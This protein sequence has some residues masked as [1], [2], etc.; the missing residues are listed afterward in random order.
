MHCIWTTQGEVVCSKEH[1]TQ[2]DKKE[3]TVVSV[4]LENTTNFISDPREFRNVIA[5]RIS[6]GD[7][8][9]IKGHAQPNAQFALSKGSFVVSSV[10]VP[11]NPS[12]PVEISLASSVTMRPGKVTLIPMSSTVNNRS[13][14]PPAGNNRSP[15]TPPVATTTVTTA[16]VM[17]RD[18]T[19]NV[20]TDTM[21]SLLFVSSSDA[22]RFTQG[23]DIKITSPNA[24]N[25]NARIVRKNAFTTDANIHQIV[26]DKCVNIRL[27]ATNTIQFL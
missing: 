26:L 8:D 5:F 2:I 4:K 20:P 6:Q 18:L 23:R 21:S 27:G 19:G 16:S 15:P 1:F 11:Q 14:A 3:V 25:V 12:E 10:N 9:N 17:L 24:N 13:P 7:Y 22:G